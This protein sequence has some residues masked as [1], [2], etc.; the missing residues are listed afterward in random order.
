MSSHVRPHEWAYRDDAQALGTAGLKRGFHQCVA[1]MP[2]A[3]TFRDFGMNEF[4]RVGRPFVSKECCQ[5]I[6]RELD[7][8]RRTSAL[9]REQLPAGIVELLPVGAEAGAWGA[10][11]IARRAI[12]GGADGATRRMDVGHAPDG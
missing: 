11:M 10:V 3:K 9:A 4:Q 6:H 8:L 12:A 5:P 7:R 2:A 1:D